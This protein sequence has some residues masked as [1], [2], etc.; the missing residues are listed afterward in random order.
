MITIKIPVTPDKG[1]QRSRSLTRPRESNQDS[2]DF[3]SLK[4]FIDSHELLD[5]D[6]KI[7]HRLAWKRCQYLENEDKIQSSRQKWADE[8]LQWKSNKQA[9]EMLWRKELNAKRKREAYF[10]EQK[11]METRQKLID[12][13]MEL[14]FLMEKKK[15][16]YSRLVAQAQK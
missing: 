13:Q 14:R 3:N 15:D 1:Q 16:N 8:F 2:A 12:V 6:R 10:N 5:H 4:E 7:L 11:L 9:L